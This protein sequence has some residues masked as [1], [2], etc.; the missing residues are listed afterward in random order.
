VARYRKFFREHRKQIRLPGRNRRRKGRRDIW[1]PDS[2]ASPPQLPAL[3][4][5]Q[6]INPM[7]PR[8]RITPTQ[9]PAWKMSPANSQPP[10][11]C[12]SHQHCQRVRDENNRQ[13][14][15]GHLLHNALPEHRLAR[16]K[17]ARLQTACQL[18]PKKSRAKIL[19]H[20]PSMERAQAWIYRFRDTD[21]H[22]KNRR[23]LTRRH[24]QR[25]SCAQPAP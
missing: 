10:R 6:T 20:V 4:I 25:Y 8:T 14:H 12:F 5:I 13:K 1:W 21:E 17:G 2:E 18:N 23:W 16:I 24:E 7:I 11:F 15:A 22:G 9:I 19:A 3:N